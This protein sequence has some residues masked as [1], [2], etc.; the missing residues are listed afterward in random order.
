MAN[1][2][3][4]SMPLCVNADKNTIP[5]TDAGTSGAFSEEYGWQNIN[6]LPLASG[7]KAPNRRDFNGVFALLGGI[8]YACQRGQSF[9]WVN[10]LPYLAGCVVTDPLDGNKY[11]AKN[12]VAEG[13]TNPSLD[14]TN[15]ELF[16]RDPNALTR[17]ITPA[18]N[19]RD[20]ITTSGT[21]TAPVTGWYKITAKGGGGGGGSGLSF[22]AGCFGGFGGSE[23][24]T[25]IEY[26][27]MMAG[28]T[29]NVI[30]GGGG[31]GG[32][33]NDP[34]GADGGGTSVTIG[35]MTYTAGGGG[36]GSRGTTQSYASGSGT[37]NGAVGSQGGTSYRSGD[38]VTGGSGGGNG[39]G[40]ATTSTGGNAV[41]NSGAGG[42]GG[43]A[44]YNSTQYAGGNGGDGFVWFEYFATI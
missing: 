24:G 14:P 44:L 4:L 26:I 16:G 32:T 10:T 34:K 8:A 1:P 36:G 29:A 41:A 37:I 20:V 9:E 23:G 28:D 6:S 31:T 27:R 11:N 15:W 39:A 25:T 19:T 40:T 30:I 21:Y 18:F 22:T 12:D 7:G 43:G 13:G 5:S 33:Y 3:L 35:S 2:T 42:G 38:S 17:E